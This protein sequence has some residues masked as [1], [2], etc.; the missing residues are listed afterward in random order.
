[1]QYTLF[2]YASKP[3][4]SKH[5][6]FYAAS[7]KLAWKEH[8]W[9]YLSPKFTLVSPWSQIYYNHYPLQHLSTIL[10]P[11][12][13]TFM[14]PTEGLK[15]EQSSVLNE[16]IQAGDKEEVVNEYLNKKKY[17]KASELP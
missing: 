8:I 12:A 13:Y 5:L 9:H 1:M 15:D 6:F 7:L 16:V 3:P 17:N 14:D 4:D 10:L 11:D 2:F